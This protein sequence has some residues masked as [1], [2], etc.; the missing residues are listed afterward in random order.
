MN[1]KFIYYIVFIFLINIS[2]IDFWYSAAICKYNS[3]ITKCIN[4]NKPWAWS[5]PE[6][7]KDFVCLQSNNKEEITY[8][9]VLDKKFKKVD[10][11]I[12]KYLK[13]LEDNKWRYFWSQKTESFLW[14]IQDIY[15]KF[16]IFW[17]YWVKYN[18]LCKVW[19]SEKITLPETG[20]SLKWSILEDSMAC[21]WWKTN[22]NQA[23]DFF[24]RSTC[25]N[26]AESKLEIYR[27]VAR[28][29]LKSN[30]NEARKDDRR[31]HTAD[32]KT[33]YDEI[34]ELFRINL[35]YL[36]RILSKLVEKT[37]NVYKG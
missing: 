10:E 36:E 3:E 33:K 35:S 7:I 27:K 26:L 22:I 21:L 20:I 24:T 11:D 32:Q 5:W 16:D 4:A 14:G 18:N 25:M 13:N 31:K 2:F 12:E 34:I 1:K 29:V 19:Y 9:I 28:D 37:R 23:K 15:D 17:E 8:Q 30:K 6:S